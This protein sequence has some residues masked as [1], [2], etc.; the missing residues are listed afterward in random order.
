DLEIDGAERERQAAQCQEQHRLVGRAGSETAVEHKAVVGHRGL[1]I[2]NHLAVRCGACLS[3]TRSDANRV[4]LG[5]AMPH[6]LSL[7]S[8][9]L[10]LTALPFAV[11]GAARAQSAGAADAAALASVVQRYAQALRSKDIEALV[12]L[13]ADDGVFMPE[14]APAASG[15][16]ALRTAYRTIF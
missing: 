2:T 4:S 5:E 13:Y 12:A 1:L 3:G 16:A 8:R 14:G 15:R 6:I 11:A 10:A 7:I 9:R